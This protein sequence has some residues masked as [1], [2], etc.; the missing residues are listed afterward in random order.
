MVHVK[1]CELAYGNNSRCT[2]LCFYVF[3]SLAM[4]CGQ[5]RNM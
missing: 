2:A 4:A 5:G 1:I 3:Y